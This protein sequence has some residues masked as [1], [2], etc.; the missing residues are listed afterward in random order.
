MFFRFRPGPRWRVL[1]RP[2]FAEVS[3]PVPR[4]RFKVQTRFNF[5]IGR[6]RRPVSQWPSAATR[7]RVSLP[8]FRNPNR[9]RRG[10]IGFLLPP[11]LFFPLSSN[12]PFVFRSF[13]FS[14]CYAT[15]RHVLMR[16]EFMHLTRRTRVVKCARWR[17]RGWQR[18]CPFSPS[19]SR[20]RMKFP[21]FAAV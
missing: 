7:F 18:R 13:L 17:W 4:S 2:H 8:R 20:T 12:V 6:P 9:R 15:S 19:P 14:F 1:T 11:F 16:G 10:P 3:V 21:R 5:E